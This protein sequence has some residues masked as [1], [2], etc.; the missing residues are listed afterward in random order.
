MQK[1]IF[2]VLAITL[3]TAFSAPA[4]CG[5]F[6]GFGNT[7]AGNSCSTDL[8]TGCN[9]AMDGFAQLQKILVGDTSAFTFLIADAMRA[10]SSAMSSVNTC[11]YEAHFANLM[12]NIFKIYV[13]VMQHFSELRTDAQCAVQSFFAEDYMKLGEC[14]GDLLKILTTKA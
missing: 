8:D 5:F 9:A 6:K 11:A 12:S 3:A 7:F 1:I 14:V 4:Y 10:Y 13:I 2:V